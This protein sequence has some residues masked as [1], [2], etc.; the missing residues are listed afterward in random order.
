MP[1]QQ[2]GGECDD[3]TNQSPNRGAFRDELPVV[4]GHEIILG[5][6][7]YLIWLHW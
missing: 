2:H 4:L 1:R 3:Q 7:L 5:P 6:L